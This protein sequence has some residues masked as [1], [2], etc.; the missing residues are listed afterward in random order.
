MNSLG[1]DLKEGYLVVEGLEKGVDAQISS[2]R[3][4]LVPCSGGAGSAAGRDSLQNA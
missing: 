1:E 2:E 4:P 3:D